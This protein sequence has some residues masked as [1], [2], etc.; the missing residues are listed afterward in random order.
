MAT[1]TLVR[2]PTDDEAAVMALSLRSKGINV[3][4]QFWMTPSEPGWRILAMVSPDAD[5]PDGYNLHERILDALE[6][7]PSPTK[8]FMGTRAM[9]FGEKEIGWQLGLIRSGYTRLPDIGPYEETQISLI[10]PASEVLKHGFLHA[11]PLASSTNRELLA[12]ASFAPFGPGGFIPT[13]KIKDQGELESLF[14][15][16]NVPAEDRK[17]INAELAQGR[18]SSTLLS[19]IG[20][21][22]LYKWDLV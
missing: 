3:T 21:D 12:E 22:V 18:T 14:Q 17:Q 6:D 16:L 2:V 19:N 13:R 11:R 9:V 5:G 20:L 1:N 7:L 10:P 8:V 15:T 4:E